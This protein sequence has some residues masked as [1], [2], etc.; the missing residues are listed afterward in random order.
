MLRTQHRPTKCMHYR[1]RGQRILPDAKAK[2]LAVREK[3]NAVWNRAFRNGRGRGCD[4]GYCAYLG[5]MALERAERS[6][7]VPPG[8]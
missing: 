3:R 2:R 4:L 8:G 6:G 1:K 5:D 7:R